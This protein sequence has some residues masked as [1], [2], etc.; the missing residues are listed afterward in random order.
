MNDQHR[1]EMAA[2]N[3][4]VLRARLAKYEDAQGVPLSKPVW[5]QFYQDGE[6]HN[7]YKNVPNHRADTEAAG[8][9]TRDL[10]AGSAPSHGE[11]VRE[12]YRMVKVGAEGV[13]FGNAWFSH[14][15][16]TGYTAEQLNGGNCR[17]TGR[18][19]MDWLAATPSAGSQKEQGE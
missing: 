5:W 16:I 7:G 6:W 18:A 11:Q 12:G 8:Y 14:E 3:C 2:D 9:L 10:Y 4:E 15:G 19:Y 17:V 13:Q 1:I